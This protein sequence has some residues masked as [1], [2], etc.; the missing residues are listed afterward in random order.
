M[1]I[2]TLTSSGTFY[3]T[4]LHK[5]KYDEQMQGCIKKTVSNLLDVETS[6]DRPGMLLGKIQSG[7]TRTF[8]GVMGLACDNG[9]DVI[10][11]LTKGTKALAQQTIERLKNEYRELV[12]ADK[13]QIFDIMHFPKNLTGF[14]LEQKLVLVVKKEMKN[15]IRLHEAIFNTYPSL[16]GKKILI[17]DDEADFASI[18]FSKT[19][20]E[21]T[22]IKKIAGSI[23]EFRQKTTQTS[24]LQVTATPYSLYLQPEDLVLDSRNL[25]FKP[26]KPSFTVLVPVHD[27]YIGGDYYFGQS[28]DESS[29]AYHLFESV[30]EDELSILK[31]PD[32]RSFK[33][34]ECLTSRRVKSLRNSIVNFVVGACIRRLQDRHQERNGKK[35]SFIIHTEQNKASHLWQQEIIFEIKDR[36][37]EA[38]KENNLLYDQLVRDSYE[39]LGK[40]MSLYPADDMPKYEIVKEEVRQSLEKDY[41]MITVVN[42]EKDVNELLDD[43]GQLKL[44]TPLNIF[45]GGQI[46]DRGITIGNLIGFYYGRRPKTF[47]QDTVLQHSR[48]YGARPLED[49]A[50]TRFYTTPDIYAVMKRIHEFDTAL[51]EA[52]EKG[53]HDGGVV[54]IQKDT[55][56]KIIPCSPNKILLSS[57]TTLKP[58][59]RMLPTGFK[60]KA[61]TH[62]KK[63]VTEI[64]NTIASYLQGIETE[65]FLIPVNEAIKIIEK[66]ADTFEEDNGWDIRAYTA[67]LDYLCQQPSDEEWKGKVWVIVRKGREA[68]RTKQDGRF[69]N[70]PDSYQEK[71][72][73]REIAQKIPA[74]ILL[75]QN[76]DEQNGWTGHPFWWPIL[77]TPQNTKIVVFTS[78]QVG[79]E[80]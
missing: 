48:M 49:L 16:A 50:V 69:E 80:E 65:P 29:M 32:R 44:R 28:E 38:A 59:V 26:I 30:D 46:L 2:Q 8:L 35:Y 17:I 18:G 45:I 5:N 60:V 76:G 63:T 42:S 62:I 33:I 57:T 31:K 72:K 52:F 1:M 37:T 7:K 3:Q 56:N 77:V 4:L 64:D 22:E 40:S 71:G 41:T 67:S 24:Y 19:R 61:K 39:N 14:E 10:I 23:D 74:L 54:F 11:V 34:E 21:G 13:M 9:Y 70:S 20:Q 27:K 47:Q 73:A 43:S 55:E 36:L 66:V 12:E 51:R 78:E 6:F 15:M 53:D 75:R 58:S 79:V 68:Q 25:V